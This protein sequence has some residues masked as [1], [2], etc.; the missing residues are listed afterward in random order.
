M[1]KIMLTIFIALLSVS[2]FAQVEVTFQ[3][4]MGAQVYR[5]L[6]DPATGDV[7]V[8]GSFQTDAGD[9]GGDWQGSF[10][11]LTDPDN[12][13]IYTVTATFPVDSAGKEYFFKF[14]KN[15]DGWEGNPDRPFTLSAT[16]PQMLPVYWFN[17]DSSYVLENQV[18]NTLNFVAD[19]TS[20]Y[21]S[22]VG[23]FDPGQD[24][25]LVM[26]LDWDGLG[27]LVSDPSERRLVED[28]FEP[29][30]FRTSLTFIGTLDDVT[31]WKFKAYPD[32]RFSNTGW[33]S[34]EDRNHTYVED[35]AVIDL[36][37]IVPRIDPLA[38]PIV[39]DVTLIFRVDVTNAV[40][41]YNQ[42]PIDPAS[43]IFVG[44]RG[45]ADFLGS[46]SSGGNWLVS[47]TLTGHMKV[48][49]DAGVN[50]DVTAG[51][52]IW[53][54]TVIAPAGSNGGAYEYKFAA[55][56]PN[57]DTVNGGSSPLDNE[58]GFGQNH[59]LVLVEGGPFTYVHQFGNF[60][61]TS[62]EKIDDLAPN[63]FELSQNYPNPFNPSTTIRY[64]VPEAGLVNIKVYSLI[65][66]EVAALVN[67]ALEVGVY[68]VTFDASKLSS[69]IYF[70]T[71]KAGSFTSTKKMIMLK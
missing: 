60:S 3:V 43:I 17:D 13:T 53:S 48:L 54:T 61:A 5:G 63:S 14:V 10:F 29:G 26:G 44:M 28:P 7:V 23:Y 25:I 62:I 46:W 34:G 56:Y 37:P 67:E 69:G 66:E 33:E 27:T 16:S 49:N 65:G 35:G 55:Y 15:G 70:Y 39:N 38:P 20:I 19:L 68:E 30:I 41:R 36:D 50:G 58:G 52:N 64:N 71:M 6:F 24:S 45:G 31:R 59:K 32:D 4:D 8:R 40:N 21:G 12:D 18:T 57:A 11:T 22:G 51:D 47:D 9:P 42:Q 1:K 2:V